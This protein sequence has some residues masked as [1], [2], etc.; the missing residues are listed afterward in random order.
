MRKG[1]GWI[2]ILLITLLAGCD[3]VKSPNELITSPQQQDEQKRNMEQQLRALL[4]PSS[5]LVTPVQSDINQSIFIEDLDG[6]G[7]QEA[8]VL[9]RNPQQKSQV[10]IVVLQEEDSEWQ[11]ATHIE[12][13]GQAIDY[14][15]L[16]DLD[17]DGVMEVVAGLGESEFETKK[18][19]MIYIWQDRSLKKTVERSYE[20]LDISDYNTDERLELLLVDGERR[21]F[22]TAELFHYE[23]GDLVSLSAVSLNSYAFHQRI[24][25]GKLNDGNHA[26]FIDS[27]IGVNAMLTEIVAYDGTKLIKVGAEQGDLAFKSLPLYSADINEDN[28]VEVGETY[29]PQ[30]W[31]EEDPTETPYIVSYVTYSING[32]SKK[33][34][35]R[36]TNLEHTF[37][38]D[39]PEKWHGKVTIKSIENGIQLVSLVNNKL[40]FEVKWTNKETTNSAHT[41]IKETK[42]MIYYTTL[43][44][45]PDFPV[46]TFHLEQFEF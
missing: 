13:D 26:L 25:S 12:P 39:I 43:E 42:D 17:E 7:Q 31:I 37:Y 8:I 14:F 35:E 23:L 38:I 20:G 10:H 34:A 6:D 15:G 5:E 9:Y 46:E 24:K 41:I 32:T 1:I 30:G 19:L 45:H 40:L 16:H 33:T 2:T 18:Q 4:P 3:L 28:I 36:A 11:E 22:Y 21:A 29:L 44:E 27:A